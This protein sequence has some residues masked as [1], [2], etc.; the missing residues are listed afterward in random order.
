MIALITPFP[1]SLFPERVTPN[2]AAASLNANLGKKAY[3][4]SP[5]LG[6]FSQEWN[7][8]MGHKGFEVDFTLGSETDREFV[9]TRL[10]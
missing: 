1:S 7:S 2:A 9:V 3:E 4:I 6:R 8:P 5:N 10:K